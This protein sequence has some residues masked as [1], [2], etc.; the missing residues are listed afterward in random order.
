MAQDD[1]SSQSRQGPRMKRRT[2]L[3]A[4]AV[5][6]AGIALGLYRLRPSPPPPSEAPPLP[7]AIPTAPFAYG[8]WRDVY[9]EHWSWDRVVRST[10]FVNCWYQAHCAWNVYVKD[11]VVWREEQA[12]DY[13]QVR[14]D[15]PDFNPRGCQKG[16][17]YSERMYDPA[18]VRYPLKRVGPRGSGKWKRVSWE[19]ALEEIADSMLDTITQE[20][21]DRVIWDLGPLFTVGT[22]SAAQQ[23]LATALDSTSLDMNSEIGDGHRGAGETFGKIVFERSADDYFFSDLI[24]VWGGNPLFTQIPNAHFLTE[25][26]YNGAKLVCIA[27]DYSASSV[28]AD[29]WVPVKPGADAALGLGIAHVLVEQNLFDRDFLVEQTDLPLLVREDNQLYLRSSDLE[30]GGSDE[31][32]YLHDPERGVVAAPRRSLALEGLKPSLE[33]RFEVTLH[34]G[35]RVGV[36]PVFALLRERLADYSP[37][38]ASRLCGTHPSLIRKLA[39]EMARAK[40]ASMVTTSNFSKYYH[41]NLIERTQALVFALAGH[42]GKQG[43]GFVAFPFLNHDG[44]ERLF[45]GVYTPS[46]RANI[47]WQLLPGEYR[48]RILDG[49]TEEMVVYERTRLSFKVGAGLG[50]SGALFWYVHGG[51]LEAS[52]ALQDWDPY[53]KRPVREVLEESLE[54]GWQYLWPKPGDDPRVL[55]AY[56]SNPLRRVRGYPLLL[57]HLWPKLNTVV[58]LT[59]RMNSTALQSDYVLPTAGWYERTEHKWVTPLMPFIHAG[60]K[61]TSFYQAKSDWEILSRLAMAVQRRARERGLESFTDRM[62]NQRSL[63]DIYDRVS[64]WGRF[65]PTD[66]DK[67]AGALIENASNLEGV[68][69]ET[70]KKRGWARFTSTGSSAGGIGNATEIRPDDTVT[71]LTKHVFDKQPYPTLSRR[72]QFYLDHELYQEMGE[73]LPVHKDPP[74]AGGKYPLLLGGGHTRWSI[75]AAWR[76][77]R[78]MLQQQRGEP[79]V[80]MSAADAEA[81]GL[82]DG[83]QARVYNDLDSFHVM[84]KVSPGVMPGQLILYHAWENYQFRDGKGFQNLIPAPLNPVELA[85]GQFHLRPMAIAM[86]PSHTDRDTRVEVERA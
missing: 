85:G 12:G 72:M 11:G 40:S 36:R 34:D 20:G 71:P 27:P 13:P 35:S 8:D 33:G 65:G 86:Q 25:S 7:P 42:Y 6:A 69:W 61:A 60:E 56:G 70:L 23:F 38:K 51:L 9:T 74:T 10:H 17:C 68:E 76:D 83:D 22:M 4:A 18:R 39:M 50:T 44:F 62:G 24:L 82:R 80:C 29:L 2:F 55:F 75:H 52:E 84:V 81:R 19:L 15:V 28:H 53:L 58:T 21:S 64:H 48:N 37:E 43:S 67:L 45:F 79:L 59:W 30:R 66:D 41:G 63:H 26:R 73:Q 14:P 32:L 54:K 1:A 16:G 5:G 77:D 49:W 57:K 46:E 3:G 31:E 47:L 78:L